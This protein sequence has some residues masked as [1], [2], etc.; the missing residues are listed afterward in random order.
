MPGRA[1]TMWLLPGLALTRH[2]VGE[3]LGTTNLEML[4]RRPRGAWL[5][6]WAIFHLPDILSLA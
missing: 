4:R 1:C 3:G 5:P 6:G 2:K